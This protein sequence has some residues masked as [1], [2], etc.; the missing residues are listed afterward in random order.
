MVKNKSNANCNQVILD[1]FWHICDASEV[2]R[3]KSIQT[4][5]QTLAHQ[6]A[7]SQNTDID[8]CLHRL[9]KGL[10]SAREFSRHGFC[11]L[12]TQILAKFPENVHLNQVIEMSESEYGKEMKNANP[13]SAISWALL[14]GCLLKSE[15]INIRTDEQILSQIFDILCTL[16]TK[17]NYVE[18]MVCSLLGLFFDIFHANASV[19][20]KIVVTRIS[21]ED[22]GLF[23]IYLVLLAYQKFPSATKS[24]FD[25]VMSERVYKSNSKDYGKAIGV[26]KETTK[27]HPNIHPINELLI[28]TI[29]SYEPKNAEAFFSKTV[30][31]IFKVN[32]E[33][34][35]LGF[36]IVCTLLKY[37]DEHQVRLESRLC[38]TNCLLLPL[39]FN[40]II[41]EF[42]ANIYSNSFEQET[43]FAQQSHRV[44]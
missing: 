39:G 5:L 44:G 13:E 23:S 11:V 15:S 14:I 19:F 42:Y 36:D 1:H 6:V 25:R 22:G 8:Y 27:Y 26:V 21:E 43:S 29:T 38:I 17:K 37:C 41:T 9:I 16:G 18:I 31:E 2:K 24:L 28:Q 4:I 33:K 35:F 40:C 7:N 30:E 34:T 3:V 20:E 32:L 10:V 12:L